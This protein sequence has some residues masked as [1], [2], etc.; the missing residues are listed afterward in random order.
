MSPADAEAR[1]ARGE[2]VVVIGSQPAVM[3]RRVLGVHDFG[4]VL[5]LDNLDQGW[6]P[7]PAEAYAAVSKRSL[8]RT[9]S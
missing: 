2:R 3:Q 5:D 1:A 8:S 7:M 9:R 6:S 4:E